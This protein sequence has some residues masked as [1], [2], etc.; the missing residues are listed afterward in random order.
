MRLIP[1][2]S[3]VLAFSLMGAKP[4][5]ELTGRVVGVSDG[6]TLTLLTPGKTQLKVRLDQIDAPEKDQPFGNASKQ[7]LSRQVFGRTVDVRSSGQDRYGRTLGQ[8][9]VGGGD[10]NAAMISEGAAWAYRQYLTDQGL[11]TLERRARADRRGLWAL[12]SDQVVAPWEWRSG[13][14]AQSRIDQSRPTTTRA[15]FACGTKTYCSQMTSCTEARQHLNQ[16]RLQRLDSDG[17]GT[18][19]ESLCRA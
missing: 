6:D 12:P 3:A 5:G 14:R 17:D 19:C 9:R 8:V 13:Q 2:L 1:L 16:C 11:L 10:V 18:P 4:S 15:G 7:A